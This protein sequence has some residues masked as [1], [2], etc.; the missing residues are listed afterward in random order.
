MID[1][2]VLIVMAWLSTNG[3]DGP[4][5]PVVTFQDF[6]SEAACEAAKNEIDKWGGGT[7]KA[8]EPR[9]ADKTPASALRVTCKPK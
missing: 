7:L 9:P 4:D 3:R 8:W 6:S 1:P 5:G 2:Y